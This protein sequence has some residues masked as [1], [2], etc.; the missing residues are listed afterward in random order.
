M[1]VVRCGRFAE[2]W[3]SDVEDVGVGRKHTDNLRAPYRD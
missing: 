2:H 3:F 1:A